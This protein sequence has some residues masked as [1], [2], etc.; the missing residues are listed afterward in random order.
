MKYFDYL[1]E[2][3]KRELFFI[4]PKFFSR[5]GEKE[6]I[7]YA[8]GA[9]LYMPGTRTSISGDILGAKSRGLGSMV[10]CLED[11]IGDAEVQKAK[12]NLFSNLDIVKKSIGSGEIEYEDL[13]LVFIRVRNPKHIEEIEE[14]VVCR[15]EIISGFVFPK[16][17]HENANEYI[18][19]LKEINEKA[20]KKFYAMP[21]F[22]SSN[23]IH[24][25]KRFESL[26]K[27]S[28]ILNENRDLILNLRIGATDFSSI[29]GLRR[30]CDV[31]VYEIAV[32]RD[33]ISDIINLFMRQGEE[34]VISGPV[35][36]YFSSGDRVLK[37]EL[38][39]TPFERYYGEEGIQKRMD[40]ID[41][42]MDKL[43][44]EILLDKLNGL[45]GK[46][47]IHPSHIRM[48]QS[49]YAVNHEEYEDAI[50]I[51][52]KSDGNIGVMKSS[53]KN[54]MNE[55][56]PHMFWAKKILKR[57]EIYGVLNEGKEFVN[58]L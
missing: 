4:E 2:E 14:E 15:K 43:I 25:E 49:L 36:E 21:I 33:A 58:L 42:S 54:K 26:R 40:I 19:E 24:R 16:F 11:A 12:E 41:Q 8:L 17:D 1:S 22:E 32:I 46:T 3:E 35:W 37:P 31:T 23:F 52:N 27:T 30:S 38:R 18:Q 50:S 39:R 20:D 47:I 7:K 55:I 34:Y 6:D 51:V 9:T 5:D 56:K 45:I 10:L 13:P 57:A 29:Y 48:V 28:H 53:Y 44:R